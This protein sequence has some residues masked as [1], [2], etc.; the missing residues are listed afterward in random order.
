MKMKLADILGDPSCV[1]DSQT[2][3]IGDTVADALSVPWNDETEI[4][5]DDEDQFGMLMTVLEEFAQTARWMQHR[6]LEGKEDVSLLR[7]NW[8]SQFFDLLSISPNYKQSAVGLCELKADELTDE[9]AEM[10]KDAIAKQ[11]QTTRADLRVA[12]TF[13]DAMFI[14]SHET[15]SALEDPKLR[16]QMCQRMAETVGG[17]LRMIAQEAIK[18]TKGD[19]IIVPDFSSKPPVQ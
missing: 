7:G 4:D 3:A 12:Q 19:K 16:M 15:V 6:V 10:Q 11:L 5:L 18:E 2:R 17:Q 14:T 9:A 13:K 1:D 8:R